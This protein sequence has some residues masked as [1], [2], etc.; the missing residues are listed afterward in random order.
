MFLNYFLRQPQKWQVFV[1]YF[2]GKLKAFT[3]LD[4]HK[5]LWKDKECSATQRL[6]MFSLSKT[7]GD[8]FAIILLSGAQRIYSMA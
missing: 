5:T 4:H 2:T 1:W 8:V 3:T 7:G 6:F